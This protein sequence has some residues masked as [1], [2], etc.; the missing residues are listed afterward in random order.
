MALFLFAK[1]CKAD[2]K[3]QLRIIDIKTMQVLGAFDNVCQYEE[4]KGGDF[5]FA[6]DAVWNEKGQLR[7]I[8]INTGKVLGPFDNVNHF[9]ESKEGAFLFAKDVGWRGERPAAHY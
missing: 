1:D 4:S 6:R 2:E 8:E 5:L 9:Y 3:G 7:I